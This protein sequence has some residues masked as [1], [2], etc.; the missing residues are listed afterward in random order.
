MYP[1]TMFLVEVI[2]KFPETPI[3]CWTATLELPHPLALRMQLRIGQ[4]VLS[5]LSKKSVKA[6]LT[7]TVGVPVL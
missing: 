7:T 3:D 2:S 6:Y 1:R 5:E 4:S